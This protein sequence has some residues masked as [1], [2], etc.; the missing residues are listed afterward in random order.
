MNDDLSSEALR[1]LY[2][3]HAAADESLRKSFEQQ[4]LYQGSEVMEVPVAEAQQRDLFSASFAKLDASLKT[5]DHNLEATHLQ[6]MEQLRKDHSVSVSSEA[7]LDKLEALLRS[8][9]KVGQLRQRAL[10]TLGLVN[11]AVTV[12]FGILILVLK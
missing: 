11:L 6:R 1:Q 4:A 2:K 9:A 12:L 10:F 8:Q 5:I 3:E 7:K